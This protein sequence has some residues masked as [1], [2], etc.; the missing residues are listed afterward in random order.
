MEAYTDGLNEAQKLRQ[1]KVDDELQR[2][3]NIIDK[4]MKQTGVQI[5]Y[6]GELCTAL[7]ITEALPIAT[8][9]LLKTSSFLF[10]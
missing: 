8:G 7:Q 1:Q 3:N 4:L 6:Q 5:L 10:V 9:M 2:M